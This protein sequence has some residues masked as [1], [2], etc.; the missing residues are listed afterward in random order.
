M[1][2]FAMRCSGRQRLAVCNACLSYSS[3]AGRKTIGLQMWH[4][5]GDGEPAGWSRLGRVASIRV[6]EGRGST[7]QD[8][9]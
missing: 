7:G 1:R 5:G 8:A 4:D 2:S 3:A 9:G 6:E